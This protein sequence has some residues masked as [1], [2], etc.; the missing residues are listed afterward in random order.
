MADIVKPYK[1]GDYWTNLVDSESGESVNF[2]EVS[3]WWDGTPMDDSKADGDLY[4]KLP[5]AEG[6]GYVRRIDN[7]VQPTTSDNIQF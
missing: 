3:T 4:R 2:E 6:G 1:V 7:G 5:A